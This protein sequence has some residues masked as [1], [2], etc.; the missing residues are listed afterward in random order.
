MTL[1]L[2]FSDRLAQQPFTYKYGDTTI[3]SEVLQNLA[4]ARRSWS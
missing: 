1:G 3:A 4:Y 2:G